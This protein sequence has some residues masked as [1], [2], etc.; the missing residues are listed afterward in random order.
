MAFRECGCGSAIQHL[1]SPDEIR[2]V[3]SAENSS[4]LGWQAKLVYYSCLTRAG[5]VPVIVVHGG[6]QE[7]IPSLVDTQRKGGYIVQ[8]PSYRTTPRGRDYAPRNSPGTLIEVSKSLDPRVRWIVLCDADV[9]FTRRP[10]FEPECSGEF[11]GYLNYADSIVRD[12][13]N[14][15][16]VAASAIDDY[17]SR[18]RCGIPYVIPADAAQE[19][20]KA[21]LKCTDLFL[22]PRWVDVMYAFGIAAALC[23]CELNTTSLIQTNLRPD[24]ELTAG[25]IHYCYN[26]ARWS[27]RRFILREQA[28]RVWTSQAPAVP[29]SVQMEIF[30]QLAAAAE[31]YS[32]RDITAR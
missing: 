15:A 3:V 25:I 2:V 14:R 9:L 8:A 32:N 26:N 29:G 22:R 30:T 1:G 27:K 10:A 19:L 5:L 24:E 7:L 31:F 23:R 12:V 6:P 13:V 21:W 18:L 16:G 17:G 11:Y 4:Y 28:D 20:G